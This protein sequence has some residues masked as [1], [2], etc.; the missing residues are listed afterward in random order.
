MLLARSVDS[1]SDFLKLPE[2][3]LMSGRSFY[4]F[5][6]RF[7]TERFSALSVAFLY[8]QAFVCFFCSFDCSLFCRLYGFGEL[9]CAN[10]KDNGNEYNGL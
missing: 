10:F 5:W 6:F 1:R 3:K 7:I 9:N 4:M 8:D 2:K